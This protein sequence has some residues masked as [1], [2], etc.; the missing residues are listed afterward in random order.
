MQLTT[1]DFTLGASN[2]WSRSG[3][4]APWAPEFTKIACPGKPDR[5][6][7]NAIESALTVR[8][9][10]VPALKEKVL[11]YFKTG[12]LRLPAKVFPRWTHEDW[13]E[14]PSTEVGIPQ[15]KLHKKVRWV[16]REVVPGR[17]G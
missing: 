14:Y 4:A 13:M 6:E 9:Q 11:A 1:S 3:A 5:M 17:A 8:G 7:A 2:R 16:I 10:D 15:F 12:E